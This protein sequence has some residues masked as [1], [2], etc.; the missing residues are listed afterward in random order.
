MA[1]LSPLAALFALPYPTTPRPARRS[2]VVCRAAPSWSSLEAAL[3]SS[4]CPQPRLIDAAL[5]PAKPDLGN[6]LTLFRERNGWCP[7]SER[8]WLTMEVK[9]LD[10][11]TVLIDNT[12]GGKPSWYR[13]NTPQLRWPDGRVQDESLELMRAL[14]DAFPDS[15]RLWPPSGV[16]PAAVS[17]AVRAFKSTFPRSA[18]PSSRAAFLYDFNGPLP[19][20]EFERTLDATD[21]WLARSPGPFFCGGAL[22]AADIAW[23]PFLERYAAQLPCLHDGLEP[24]D[25]SRWPRLAEWYD[26]MEARVPAYACRVQGDAAS[27]RKVLTVAGYGNAGAPP[28]L[29]RDEAAACRRD[30]AADADG[31]W[32]AYAAGRPHVAASPCEEAAARLVRSR[33]LLAADA[34][35]RIERTAESAADEA[36]RGVAAA[37]LALRSGDGMP[38]LSPT[39]AALAKYLA[40]R[41]C[42]PRDMGAPAAQALRSLSSA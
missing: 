4:T 32:A 34:A 19:R 6:S 38:A 20:S 13:G 23:V 42:V 28:R 12:G 33:R 15:P 18:R 31:T 1:A 14:D 5:H 39:E 35:R 25:A 9:S 2:H 41:M 8:V 11:Q 24:R 3:P 40:E 21:A 37:L 17:E 36:L 26:A 16:D 10:Y 27:W 7:Y 29:L 22:S 30:A